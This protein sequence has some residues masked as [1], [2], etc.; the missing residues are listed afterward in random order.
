M[1]SGGGAVAE[2][3]LSPERAAQ[4]LDVNPETVRNWLREG[5]LQGVKVGRL[6]RVREEDLQTFLRGN[7]AD[8]E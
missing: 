7:R 5:K 6:W 8:N 4:M 3:L 1:Y 2:K